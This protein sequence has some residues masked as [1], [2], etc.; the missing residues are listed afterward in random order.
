MI[1]LPK[2]L[3]GRHQAESHP[4]WFCYVPI[5][6]TVFQNIFER[7][8][9]QLI[10]LAFFLQTSAACKIIWWNQDHGRKQMLCLE[11]TFLVNKLRTKQ[12]LFQGLWHYSAVSI[13][14]RVFSFLHSRNK[15]AT[16]CSSSRQSD[17][18]LWEGFFRLAEGRHHVLKPG[19]KQGGR[20]L[21]FSLKRFQTFGRRR[22]M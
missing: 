22:H 18:L 14:P 13:C 17:R 20:Y 15:K 5:I 2:L 6:V 3:P 1:S 7:P 8:L 12:P 21:I 9:K 11:L 19:Q 4:E 10:N 16:L